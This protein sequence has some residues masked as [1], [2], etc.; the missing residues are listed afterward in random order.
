M[1]KKTVYAIISIVTLFLA[2]L[3]TLILLT[4]ITLDMFDIHDIIGIKSIIRVVDGHL[5]L[6]AADLICI[7]LYRI[8]VRKIE[9]TEE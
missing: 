9:T 8:S 4:G 2:S 1:S 6:V 3:I 7:L 5:G